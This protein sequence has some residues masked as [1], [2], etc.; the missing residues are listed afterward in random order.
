MEKGG[1]YRV[2][3]NQEGD[4]RCLAGLS[5]ALSPGARAHFGEGSRAVLEVILGQ[6]VETMLSTGCKGLISF[7]KDTIMDVKVL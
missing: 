5:V 1:F 6:T 3:K 4:Q 2:V 7:P